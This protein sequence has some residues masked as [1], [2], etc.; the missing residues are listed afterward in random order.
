MVFHRGKKYIRIFESTSF[1]FF[2]FFFSPTIHTRETHDTRETENVLDAFIFGVLTRLY[3]ELNELLMTPWWMWLSCIAYWSCALCHVF[4][5]YADDSNDVI[6]G[7]NRGRDFASSLTPSL[8]REKLYIPIRG[9]E[10]TLTTFRLSE[11]YFFFLSFRSIFPPPSFSL[12][13][14]WRL[15]FLS[16]H[17]IFF[18]F[19]SKT[20]I[21][22]KWMVNK[23]ENFF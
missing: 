10:E 3:S 17:F 6:A 16:I 18:F 8:F 21:I 12:P 2:S 9:N 11:L 13:C 7:F 5:M 19:P 1:F 15:L 4:L 14:F 22:M 20:R 23:Y